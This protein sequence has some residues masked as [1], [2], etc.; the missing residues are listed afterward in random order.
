MIKEMIDELNLEFSNFKEI[1]VVFLYGSY[2]RGDYS[3]KH[4]DFDLFIVLNK[5]NIPDSF[6]DKITNAI[7]PVGIKYGIKIHPEYQILT[8]HKED[9][10]LIAKM[11][12]EG[13]VIYSSG[14]FIFSAHKIGL[15]RYVIYI[16]NVENKNI[17][18]KLSQ[19]LHGRKS[20]YYKDKKK[21][22]KEYEGIIDDKNIIALGK[23]SIM[24]KQEY[25]KDI[26]GMFEKLNI[27]Y[28]VKKVVYS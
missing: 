1:A 8:I 21:I 23:G 20:W 25:I 10:T 11:I 27:N 12:E 14:L 3:K 5:K 22:V 28:K 2:A 26:E 13:K 24:V 6:K 4:S 17:R 18:T 7:M 19:I 9:E 16:F 15:T